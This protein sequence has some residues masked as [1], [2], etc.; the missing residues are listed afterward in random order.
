MVQQ[1]GPYVFKEEHKKEEIEFDDPNYSVSFYQVKT[2]H[3]IEELS[4]GSLDDEI[5]TVNAIAMVNFKHIFFAKSCL[6][7]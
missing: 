4:N 6:N 7:I 1:V 5:T 2:W 3:F